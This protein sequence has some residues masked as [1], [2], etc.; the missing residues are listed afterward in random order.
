MRRVLLRIRHNVPKNIGRI[1]L[2]DLGLRPRMLPST[3]HPPSSICPRPFM[4]RRLWL[5]SLRF[6]PFPS[7]TPLLPNARRVQI[8]LPSASPLEKTRSY[9]LQRSLPVTRQHITNYVSIH[10]A[11][12]P[13][14]SVQSQTEPP[15]Q[16]NQTDRTIKRI[17]NVSLVKQDQGIYLRPKEKWKN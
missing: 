9:R 14:E 2:D 11:N 16:V 3:P 4:Y 10:P 17:D 12:V 13:G 8:L 15:N 7:W 1:T 5:K 6:V